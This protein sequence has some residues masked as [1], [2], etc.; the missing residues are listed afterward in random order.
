MK[1]QSK[2][3]QKIKQNLKLIDYFY[4]TEI[5]YNKNK[6][7]FITFANNTQKAEE[8][9]DFIW[10]RDYFI[11]TKFDKIQTSLI[12]ENDIENNSKIYFVDNDKVVYKIHFNTNDDK[13]LG[14]ILYEV[15]YP[16]HPN[17]KDLK[18]E[19]QSPIQDNALQFLSIIFEKMEAFEI[20]L[21]KAFHTIMKDE[22]SFKDLRNK[23]ASMENRRPMCKF[24]NLR[25]WSGETTLCAY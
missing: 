24:C 3:K 10:R 14:E 8:I 9:V 11:N 18:F 22:F 20:S 25:H 5:V 7:E 1:K 4:K 19:D 2:S 23:Y 15:L 16:Q 17:W 21:D 6:F 13:E 12:N